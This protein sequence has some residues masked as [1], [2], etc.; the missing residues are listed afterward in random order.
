VSRAGKEK[1]VSCGTLVVDD[2]GRLLICHVTGTAKW[3][4]PK[5]LLDPGEDTLAAAMR[6][7][8]EEAGLVFDASRFQDLG[9]FEYRRDKCLHLYKVEVGAE[10]PDLGHLECRSFFAHHI[11]GKPTPET[12]GFRWATRDEVAKLCWPRMAE[13]LL[14][15]DW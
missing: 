5:G 11:T 13:R 12:D 7:L 6:E 3:D 14:S 8:V 2:A 9:R 15:L 1:D 4:I 10:L